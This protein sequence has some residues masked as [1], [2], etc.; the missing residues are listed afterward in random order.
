MQT[1]DSVQFHRRIRRA[2]QASKEDFLGFDTQRQIAWGYETRTDAKDYH[3]DGMRR[4]LSTK[5]SRVLFQYTLK[6]RGEYEEGEK[7][8][9]VEPDYGFTV[10]LPSAHQYYLPDGPGSWTFFW[11]IVQHPFI[12]ER[13]RELRREAAAVQSWKVGSPALSAAAVLFESAC[14]G[15]MRDV[16]SFEEKVL[17]WLLESERELHHRRYPQDERQRWLDETRQVVRE[18]LENPPTAAELAEANR[19]ERTMFAR[20]FKA[21]TGLSPAAFVTEVRLEEALKLLRTPAKLEEVAARTGFADANHF[22]K[23]F[24]RHFHSTPGAY[25]RLILKW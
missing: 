16:W 2:F 9:S 8:W 23:V 1:E 7:L 18:R 25:R 20:K 3:W 5:D 17:A 6:G 21:K 11:F 14:L 22:C 15:Q 13:V 4:G 12:T 10:I 24:R 19:L